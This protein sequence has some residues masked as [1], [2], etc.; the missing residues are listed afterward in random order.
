MVTGGPDTGHGQVKGG[1]GGVGDGGGRS[2]LECPLVRGEEFLKAEE[3]SEQFRADTLGVV[4]RFQVDSEAFSPCSAL[5]LG[6]GAFTHPVFAVS[7]I[8][9]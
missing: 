7:S 6:G 3:D 4:N 9:W 2:S 1:G 8:V 5:L